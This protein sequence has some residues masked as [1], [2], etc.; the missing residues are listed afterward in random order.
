VIRRKRLP[1]DLVPVHDAFRLAAEPVERAKEALVEA[2]PTGRGPGRPL[3]DA[4]VD[5][6]E[7]LRT[8]EGL[9]P[10]WRHPEVEPHWVA[11]DEALAESLREAEALRV[12]PP[13]LGFESLQATVGELIGPLEAFYDAA[14]R[15]LELRRQ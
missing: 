8:A 13:T 11:C 1:P 5:F 15:F 12:D 9:M 6:E 2:V 4:L 7:G 10:A 14:E 3:A